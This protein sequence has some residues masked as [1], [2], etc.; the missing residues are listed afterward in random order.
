MEPPRARKAE[1]KSAVFAEAAVL[2]AEGRSMGQIL[3]S[4]YNSFYRGVELKSS[5]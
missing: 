1:T 4:A 3:I 2:K 5:L